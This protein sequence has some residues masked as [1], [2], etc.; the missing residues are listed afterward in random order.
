L[1]WGLNLKEIEVC[2]GNLTCEMWEMF[3]GE[4][5]LR[6]ISC[7]LV[8]LQAVDLSGCQGIDAELVLEVR[9]IF[10]QRGIV[11]C[12]PMDRSWDSPTWTNPPNLRALEEGVVVPV[13]MRHRLADELQYEIEGRAAW[14]VA[15]EEVY[16]CSRFEG[17]WFF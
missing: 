6:D 7:K 4:P 16:Y 8:G 11:V 10:S 14:K 9:E 3:I 5:W 2:F 1:N 13:D 17:I 15:V 12:E